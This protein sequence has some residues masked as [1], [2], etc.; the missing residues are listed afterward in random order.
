M[1][2][3]L[4]FSHSSPFLPLISLS[5]VFPRLLKFLGC[6]LFLPELPF[7]SF[8]PL[9]CHSWVFYFVS[10]LLFASSCSLNF[11]FISNGWLLFIRGLF[12]CVCVCLHVCSS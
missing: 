11:T 6:D 9:S 8:P 1:L 3:S 7:S 5:I 12:V 2:F 4:Y 10:F